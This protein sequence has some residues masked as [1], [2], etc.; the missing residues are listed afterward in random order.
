MPYD[1]IV[2][3]SG[4]GG[5]MTALIL[6]KER[7]KVL[8]LEQLGRPGGLMRTFRRKGLT[9][10]TGVHCLGSLNEGQVL[11][12][13]FKYVGVLDRLRLV[14]M[15]PAGFLEFHYGPDR[16]RIP[17]GISAFRERLVEYFG[18]SEA[19]DRFITDMA[20]AVSTFPL[21]NLASTPERPPAY[22]QQTSL[23][24]YLD[25]LTDSKRL[26][27]VLSSIWPLYGM[28]PTE[29]PL[30]V[31][32]LVLD[33]F[34]NGSYRID[35]SRTSL[36]KA[37]VS[38]LEVAGGELRCGAKVTAIDCPHGEARGVRLADGEF[39]PSKRVVFTGHTKLFP[40]LCSTGALRPAYCRRLQAAPETNGVFGVVMAWPDERC[41]MADRDVLLYDSQD[42]PVSETR[43]LLGVPDRPVAI[44]CSAQPEPVNGRRAV[45]AM[46]GM[47][48]RELRKWE[49]TVTGHR[50]ADYTEAKMDLAER[51][52]SILRERWPGIDGDM[53]I[54]DTFSPLSYRDYTLSPAGSAYGVKR[55]VGS[56]RTSRFSPATHVKQ[57]YLAG[58]NIG[59]SGVLGTVISSIEACGLIIGQSHLVNA[60]VKESS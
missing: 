33:S 58:Q 37:F 7:Q 53:E 36:V 31:H 32:F 27:L 6:A 15:D 44:Y 11:W 9:F 41:P 8:V 24:T 40:S 35:E 5:M 54:L 1:T 18:S 21:Y 26:Q 16:Y 51:L 17:C 43:P 59:L 3:G 20:N 46:C 2:I 60:I 29:C 4:V 55:A 57:L 56:L 10:P 50:P 34:L 19:I 49:N 30:Y 25:E 52:V 23:Q 45:V 12:R 22:I 13:C 14:P 48:C 39:I 28:V 38:E 42:A 47:D